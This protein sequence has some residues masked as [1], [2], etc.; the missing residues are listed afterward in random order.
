MNHFDFRQSTFVTSAP[1]IRGLPRDEGI[2]IAFAGRSNAGKSSALNRLADQKK[3][4]KEALP[5]AERAYQLSGQAPVI[6]DTLGW[7]HFKLGDAATAMTYIDRAAKQLPKNADITLHLAELHLS[8]GDQPLAKVYLDIALK[9]DP[10]LTER[11]DV[12]ALV[13]RIR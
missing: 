8:L 3:Q 11:D 4:P 7:V 9:L 5:L 1:D 12:K 2:E 6:G 13:A 10:K